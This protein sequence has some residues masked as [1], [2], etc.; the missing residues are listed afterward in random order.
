M[1]EFKRLGKILGLHKKSALQY[2]CDKCKLHG[3]KYRRA[4]LTIVKLKVQNMEEK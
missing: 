4:I 2:E 3:A 1:A